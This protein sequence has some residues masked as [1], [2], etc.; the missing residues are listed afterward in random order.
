MARPA[1]SQAARQRRTG[2]G[3]FLRARAIQ[4]QRSAMESMAR[5]WQ[6]PWTSALTMSVMGLAIALPLLLF[7]IAQNAQQLSTKL[8]DA[9]QITVFLSID[10]DADDAQ[11]MRTALAAHDDVAG[12]DLRTPGQGLDEVRSWPGFRDALDLLDDNPLP[13]VLIVEPATR[14][15]DDGAL[16]AKLRS[17]TQVDLVQYDATWQARMSAAAGVLQRMFVVLALLL[18]LATTLVV[19][20]TVRLD[21]Q[22]RAEEIAVMQLMGADA[23]FVRRPFLYAGLWYGLASGLL[24]VVAVGIIE[25]ALA[26][27]LAQLVD[28]YQQRFVLHGLDL[29]TAGLVVAAGA[30][31]GWAGA[32]LT[33]TAY[34]IRGNRRQ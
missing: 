5:L 10:A 11:A 19:G 21:L 2:I 24:A 12:V 25:L 7:L 18:A 13:Y 30:M 31:L 8:R 17:D 34:L 9:G 23:T 27:P 29:R 32:G 33:S 22:A 28:S 6:R 20:N 26:T 1:S 14:L 3:S 16:L 15:D 4:H